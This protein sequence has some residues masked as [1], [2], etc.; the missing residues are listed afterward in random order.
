MSKTSKLLLLSFFVPFFTFGSLQSLGE[1][2]DRLANPDTDEYK[3]IFDA[4]CTF[5]FAGTISGVLIT[6]LVA[7]IIGLLKL[8]KKTSNNSHK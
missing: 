1:A 3:I 5:L 7:T 8:I 4:V 2:L 6:I